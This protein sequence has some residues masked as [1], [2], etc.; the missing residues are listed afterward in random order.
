MKDTTVETGLQA[1]QARFGILG[2]VSGVQEI[3]L[4]KR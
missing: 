4:G 3:D 1:L 2:E